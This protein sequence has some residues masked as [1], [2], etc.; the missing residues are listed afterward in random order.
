MYTFILLACFAY[1]LGSIP[2]GLLISKKF[3]KLDIT[4]HGSNNIGATNVLR[5]GNKKVAFLTLILDVSK[6]LIPIL[7]SNK[8]GFDHLLIIGFFAL[9]GHIFPIWLNFKGGKGIATYIGIL[10]ATSP[11]MAILFIIVWLI[12]FSIYRYSS[13]SAICSVICMPVIYLSIQIT[14]FSESLNIYSTI[15]NTELF[16]LNLTIILFMTSILIYRHIE[17]IKRLTAGKEA[18]FKDK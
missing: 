16:N 11:I 1:L 9:M 8:L 7:I 12:I 17:N 18:K 3:L 15:H 2:F 13:L 10:I 14:P 6:G 4:K 5:L